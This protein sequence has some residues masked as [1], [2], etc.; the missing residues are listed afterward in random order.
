MTQEAMFKI[1]DKCGRQEIYTRL[2]RACL[3]LEKYLFLRSTSEMFG[4]EETQ[5]ISQRGMIDAVAEIDVLID[6]LTNTCMTMS[7]RYEV[8][9]SE[10]HQCRSLIE[11]ILGGDEE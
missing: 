8:V 11:E 1:V 3:L 10:E 2:G 9:C 5:A 6:I 7:E 4:L